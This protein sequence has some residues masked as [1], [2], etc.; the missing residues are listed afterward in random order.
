MN[1]FWAKV[2]KTPGLG[3]NGDCWEW[4][5]AK[6]RQGYGLF[7]YNGKWVTAHRTSWE[8]EHGKKP[9]FNILHHCDNPSCVR[10]SHL[11]EGTQKDNMH[12]MISK[13]RKVQLKGKESGNAKL[14]E[15]E[16]VEIFQSKES[17]RKLANRYD[18]GKSTIARIKHKKTW[19]HIT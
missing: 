5:A 8:L 15:Q 9:S 3:P 10:S 1:R 12:D 16:V 14:T 7:S 6:H 17:Q 18:V 19:S 2:N 4:T 11:F 13:G